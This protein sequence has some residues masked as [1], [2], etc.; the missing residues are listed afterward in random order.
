MEATTHYLYDTAAREAIAS[1]PEARVIV[2][3]REP[4][5]RVYSSFQYTANNL[6]RLSPRL[7]FARYVE[8]I[9]AGEPLLPRWCNHAGSAYVLER[10]IDYSR[11]VTYIEPWLGSFGGE[12]MKI[13]LLEEMLATPDL[14][15]RDV[16]SWLALGA[17][18]IPQGALHGRNRTESIRSS[19]AHAWA[20]FTNERVRPPESVRGFAKW[21]YGLMQYRGTRPLS[22]EDASALAYLRERYRCHNARLAQ[23]AGIDLRAWDESTASQ[24]QRRMR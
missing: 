6:A 8:L 17:N 19:R 15:V 16:L 9:E 20:R 1:L 13:L 2:V 11:Y 24:V 18:L 3:L 23:L 21:A 7:T 4:A 14:A 22:D 5:A 10:D 12:R